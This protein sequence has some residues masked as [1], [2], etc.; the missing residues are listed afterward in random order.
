MFFVNHFDSLCLRLSDS[1]RL[2]VCSCIKAHRALVTLPLRDVPPCPGGTLEN[3]PVIYCREKSDFSCSLVG[4]GARLPS[5]R[6]VEEERFAS[7]IFMGY[8]K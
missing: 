5:I 3:R 4:G 7:S 8:G 2:F 6:I 1:E